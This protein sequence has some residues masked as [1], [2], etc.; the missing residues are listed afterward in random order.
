MFCSNR[1]CK[2]VLLLYLG[3]TIGATRLMGC[4]T[5]YAVYWESRKAK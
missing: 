2:N 5:C 4:P 1:S 3:A